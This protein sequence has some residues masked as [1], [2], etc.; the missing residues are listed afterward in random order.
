MVILNFLWYCIQ[1]M[2]FVLPVAAGGHMPDNYTIVDG[3]IGIATFLVLFVI[4]ILI[5]WGTG[6]ITLKK[7]NNNS[8]DNKQNKN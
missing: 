2:I 7:Q 1:R 4:V 5:L 3:L 6:V 8:L